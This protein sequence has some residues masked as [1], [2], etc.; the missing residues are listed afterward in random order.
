MRLVE[1][2]CCR[3]VASFVV[4][5]V[6]SEH[7]KRI[8]KGIRLHSDIFPGIFPITNSCFFLGEARGV[9]TGNIQDAAIFVASINT[10]W[11]Y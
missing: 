11:F 2:V 5:P 9:A 1:L 4:R 8:G 3:V 7:R 6:G 10:M